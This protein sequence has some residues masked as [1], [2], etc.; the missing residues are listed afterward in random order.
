M[1]KGRKNI[2]SQWCWEH[3]IMGYRILKE[4]GILISIKDLILT[5]SD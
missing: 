5:S 3:K 2:R 1:I 4:K